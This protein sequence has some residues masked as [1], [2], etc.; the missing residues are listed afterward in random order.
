M[1]AVTSKQVVDLNKKKKSAHARDILYVF[2]FAIFLFSEFLSVLC[3]DPRHSRLS[4]THGC[5][6]LKVSLWTLS[7]LNSFGVLW[8][9]ES[10]RKYVRAVVNYIALSTGSVS[11]ENSENNIVLLSAVHTPRAISL[12]SILMLCSFMK[13]E[14][15]L[16]CSQEPTCG[17][18]PQDHT[19]FL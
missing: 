5:N 3:C 13:C 4:P 8:N 11:C 18:S 9:A 19:I 1:F 6:R 15:S 7:R 10:E 17:S 16:K 14:G 12:R 2:S